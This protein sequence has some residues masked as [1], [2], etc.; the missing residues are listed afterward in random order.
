MMNTSTASVTSA[1]TET[2]YFAWAELRS[3]DEVFVCSKSLGA[4]LSPPA[5]I[6]AVLRN[7]PDANPARLLRCEL[8]YRGYHG[9]NFNPGVTNVSDEIDKRHQWSIGYKESAV[10]SDVKERLQEAGIH[11]DFDDDRFHRKLRD[12]KELENFYVK[13]IVDFINSKP[14]TRTVCQ[15]MK[16]I[17]DKTFDSHVDATT[18]GMRTYQVTSCT[19]AASNLPVPPETSTS[20]TPGLKVLFAV[21]IVDDELSSQMFGPFSVLEPGLTRAALT[22]F[23]SSQYA[24][25]PTDVS[26]ADQ[27]LEKS[28]IVEHLVGVLLHS[29]LENK[30]LEFWIQQLVAAYAI[31]ETELPDEVGSAFDI[32]CLHFVTA[33]VVVSCTGDELDG[34]ILM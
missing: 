19:L 28:E 20:K 33:N 21:H 22:A 16:Y 15:V 11:V 30:D 17:A 29:L 2:I 9:L 34:V 4:Y 25:L 10:E 31:P 14:E 13:R 18:F 1:S 8:D 24:V 6:R 32:N 3:N 12:S 26:P 5:A 7:V 23:L 27:I